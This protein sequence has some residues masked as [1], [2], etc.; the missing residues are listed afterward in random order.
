[1]INAH[2]TETQWFISPGTWRRVWFGPVSSGQS[3]YTQWSQFFCC[4]PL[5]LKR[6]IPAVN[7][8]PQCCSYSC[9]CR[10]WRHSQGSAPSSSCPTGAGSSGAVHS[11]FL[12]DVYLDLENPGGS[13]FWERENRRVTGEAKRVSLRA[14]GSRGG[15]I[16]TQKEGSK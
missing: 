9:N 1:M 6:H 10:L 11:V 12:I 5:Q 7:T 15:R 2:S 13:G 8:T 16:L 14:S 4:H 3:L